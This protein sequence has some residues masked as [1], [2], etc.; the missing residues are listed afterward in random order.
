VEESR[1]VL[2]PLKTYRKT[3]LEEWLSKNAQEEGWILNNYLR[4][5]SSVTHTEEG[6]ILRYSVTKYVNH[7]DNESC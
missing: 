1:K 4:S 2:C 3:D 7:D 6:T 5:Q